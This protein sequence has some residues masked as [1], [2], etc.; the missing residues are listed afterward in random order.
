MTRTRAS[1]AM[2]LL[3]TTK[4]L[5]SIVSLSWTLSRDVGDLSNFVQLL[6]QDGDL[7]LELVVTGQR[8]SRQRILR[9]PSESTAEGTERTGRKICYEKAGRRTGGE[10]Q[11]GRRHGRN[12][13]KEQASHT[14]SQ[15]ALCSWSKP[16]QSC[17]NKKSCTY[18]S[19]AL[20]SVSC[21]PTCSPSKR[22][23]DPPRPRREQTH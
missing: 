5:V 12:G 22:S 7:P 11:R 8:I 4:K 19:S 9:E 18:L 1:V 23:N 17:P 13:G 21:I 3:Y 10:A 20:L 6:L 2:P 15:Q 14:Q 16:V